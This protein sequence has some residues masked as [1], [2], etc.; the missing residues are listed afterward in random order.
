LGQTLRLLLIEKHFRVLVGVALAHGGLV[1]HD[2]VRFAIMRFNRPPTVEVWLIIRIN[3]LCYFILVL[4]HSFNFVF[5][6]DEK[7]AQI[8]H[9]AR[10][11]ALHAC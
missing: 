10:I 4:L 2:E 6:R 9:L 11:S 5:F 8:F 1:L 3:V 7:L